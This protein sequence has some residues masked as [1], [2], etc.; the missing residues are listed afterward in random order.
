MKRIE[1]KLENGHKIKGKLGFYVEHKSEPDW[2]Y[3]GEIE[4]YV[5]RYKGKIV[6]ITPKNEAWAE[7]VLDDYSEEDKCFEAEGYYMKVLDW[8]L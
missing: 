2:I 4:L 3:E 6:T 8:N 5:E 1:E 7:Y